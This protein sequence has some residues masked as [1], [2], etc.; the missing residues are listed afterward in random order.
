MKA[1]SFRW[2]SVMTGVLTATILFFACKKDDV[3]KPALRSQ[4]YP[5]SAAGNSGVTGKI[6]I[7]ENTDSSFNVKVALDRSVK[8]TV[9]VLH[10]HNGSIS[11]PGN[12]AIPLTSITGTG[13]AASSITSNIKQVTLPGSTVK[14]LTYDSILVYNGYVNVHY[15]A[16]RIDSLIAQ[17]NI[18]QNKN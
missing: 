8:D 6:T 17:G 4:E 13:G 2:R 12:I 11:S 9:H 5:L 3:S 18:G 1:A 16:Y 10:I 7:S 14:V 15:S